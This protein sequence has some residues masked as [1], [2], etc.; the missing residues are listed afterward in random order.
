M[1]KRWTVG[2]LAAGLLA[3]AVP[4]QAVTGSTASGGTYDLTVEMLD[5]AALSDVVARDRGGWSVSMRSAVGSSAARWECCTALRRSRQVWAPNA[6]AAQSLETKYDV[7]L[8]RGRYR[9]SLLGRIGLVGT[10]TRVFARLERTDGLSSALRV[11]GRTG[12]RWLAGSAD[13][14]IPNLVPGD[15]YADAAAGLL[16]S[17]TMAQLIGMPTNVTRLERRDT[18]AGTTYRGSM[19]RYG[20]NYSFGFTFTGGLLTE[21]TLR[22]RGVTLTSARWR[23]ERPAVQ[24]PQRDV[25]IGAR[26][27]RAAY[28]YARFPATTRK[29][30]AQLGKYIAEDLSSPHPPNDRQIIRFI[31][32]GLRFLGRQTQG[33]MGIVVEYGY[34]PLTLGGRLAVHNRFGDRGRSVTWNAA[35]QRLRVSRVS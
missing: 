5:Q 25:S 28:A 30:A 26:A 23:Y 7:D 21:I 10:P 17:M 22:S 12:V 31:R 9:V 33:P 35:R 20:G 15:L 1:F 32:Q 19:T 6:A 34:R 3:G 4:A 2:A 13:N 16:P 29:V 27:L 18:A 24:L 11:A 8:R 14:P